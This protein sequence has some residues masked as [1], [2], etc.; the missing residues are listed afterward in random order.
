M[1]ASRRWLAASVVLAA[2]CSPAVDI[3]SNQPVTL[4]GLVAA[5]CSGARSEL[6]PTPGESP[7]SALLVGGALFTGE[8]AICPGSSA[9]R[10]LSAAFATFAQ[11]SGGFTSRALLRISPTE[12]LPDAP[13]GD[14]RLD[15]SAPN[16]AF[17]LTLADGSAYLLTFGVGLR[18]FLADPAHPDVVVAAYAAL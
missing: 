4:D 16:A 5:H 3:G 17:E 10:G 1:N 11:A 15:Y 6:Q 2:A 14:M 18:I 7:E 13:L 8:W 9:P 12:Y